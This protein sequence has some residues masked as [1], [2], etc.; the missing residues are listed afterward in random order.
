MRRQAVTESLAIIAY[1]RNVFWLAMGLAKQDASLFLE[2]LLANLMGNSLSSSGCQLW[3]R[4]HSYLL[5]LVKAVVSS[6][7]E[8]G[9]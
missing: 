2:G 5:T 7:G 6:D 1:F 3:P 9:G 8:L 4:F